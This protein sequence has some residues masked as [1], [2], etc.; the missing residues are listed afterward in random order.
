MTADSSRPLI[1]VITGRND[2][3]VPL[4]ARLI[5]K[6][7]FEVVIVDPLRD[8]L[9]IVCGDDGDAMIVSGRRVEEKQVRAV[10]YRRPLRDLRKLVDTN[11][12]PKDRLYARH[13]F[14]ELTAMLPAVF[15]NVKWVS[16]PSN[17]A[18]AENKALQLQVAAKHRLSVPRTFLFTSDPEA[19]REALE[20]Q[21]ATIVKPVAPPS[22]FGDGTTPF[23]A[24][25]VHGSDQLEWDLENLRRGPASL[26]SAIDAVG[27]WR[28]TVVGDQVF[29]A[30]VEADPASIGQPGVRDWRS[31][32]QPFRA[33][34]KLDS[35]IVR[36]ILGLV[37]E[38]QLEFAAIDLVQPPGDEEPV[39]LDLN[40]NGE[41]AFIQEEAGLPIDAAIAKVLQ[42]G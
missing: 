13:A 11:V 17:I 28:V 36:R 3:C 25:R 23:W 18:N 6:E 2:P 32:S 15:P 26:Q 8:D 19:A 29:T 10:W 31:R 33:G 30:Y 41:W 39:F 20:A 38:F 21:A 34:P 7:E 4:V 12:V 24:S 27:D 37:K 40:P 42:G 14:A 5:P 1:V 9:A 16:R 22:L 35:E